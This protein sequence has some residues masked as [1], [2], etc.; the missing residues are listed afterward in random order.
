MGAKNGL[1]AE[2]QSSDDEVPLASRK[3]KKLVPK[4]EPQSDESDAAVNGNESEEDPD[5]N[6]S[7]DDVPL[8]KRKVCFFL[9]SFQ[10]KSLFFCFSNL[11]KSVFFLIFP[12]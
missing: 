9:F 3:R 7:E 10:E 6:D 8:S 2:P 4:E 12:I 1:K 5:Y 11:E